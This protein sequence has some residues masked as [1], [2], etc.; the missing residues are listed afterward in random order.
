MAYREMALFIEEPV[1]QA[2][3][4]GKYDFK[5][6]P[7]QLKLPSPHDSVYD[8]SLRSLITEVSAAVTFALEINHTATDSGGS[9]MSIDRESRLLVN[10]LV[11]TYSRTKYRTK[12]TWR[13][14]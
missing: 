6:T 7:S 12:C 10:K 9:A 3:P 8:F 1:P 5:M 14:S 4:G 11:F 13:H 2:R